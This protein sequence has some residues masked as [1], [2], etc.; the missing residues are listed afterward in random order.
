[1]ERRKRVAQGEAEGADALVSGHFPSP[2]SREGGPT[3]PGL[4]CMTWML[5]GP[6]APASV[7]FCS[8]KL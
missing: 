4:L 5:L 6:S 2:V 3:G 7:S 1:M 8:W